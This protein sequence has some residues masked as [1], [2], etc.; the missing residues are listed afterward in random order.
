[1]WCTV[2]C[3]TDDGFFFFS[4]RRRHTRL[5]GDWSSDVCSSDLRES[6]PGR[7]SQ[8]PADHPGRRKT[9]ERNDRRRAHLGPRG[10]GRAQ[11]EPRTGESARALQHSRVGIPHRARQA[12][13]HHP[14]RPLRPSRCD[15]GREA[16]AAY[17]EQPP[18]ERGE[19]LSSRQRSDLFR[20]PA[21]RARRDRD[22]GSGNRDTPGRP[23]ADVRELSSRFE[24]REP[25][26]H[27]PGSCDREEGGGASRRRNQP[28]ER[29]RLRNPVHRY[30][31][32]TAGQTAGPSELM[33]AESR[34]KVPVIDDAPSNLDNNMLMLKVERYAATGAENGRVGLELARSDPPDLILCDVMMPEMDG[35]AVLEALRAEP[36]LAEIPFI[37]LTALDDRS[38]TRR[39]MNLG[40]DDYLP[41]PFTRNELMEAVNSRLKKF[42]NLK[43][44]LAAR[45]VPK[46]DRLT[47]KFRAQ[48]SGGD[49]TTALGGPDSG[50]PTGQIA[51]ASVLFSDIR[52]FTTY[53]ERLTSDEIAELLNAYLGTACAP[54]IRCRGAVMKFIG[55]GVM[56]L[57]ESPQ[58]EGGESH[59]QRAVRAGLAMQLAALE[60]RDWVKQ[61]HPSKSLPEFSIGV[62]IHSGE[63]LLCHVGAPGRGELTLIGD[64]VNIASRLE[65][66]TKELGWAVV[67]SEATVNAAGSAPVVGSRRQVQLRGRSAPTGAVGFIGIAA[68]D[69]DHASVQIPEDM[70]QA[71]APNPRVAP[72]RAKA[73]LGIT[74]S[75]MTGE[76]GEKR[77]TVQGY[78]VVSKVGRG[79]GSRSGEHTS[80]PPPP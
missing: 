15:H 62:G 29:G 21:Q 72:Q 31:S 78:H 19:V 24:R 56:A 80:G 16:A 41:K 32:P 74:L 60:F 63:V 6:E 46:Q 67:A 68:G 44:S 8:P 55:D 53:S 48:I 33:A 34:H 39:G 50:T 27:R 38:S 14:G 59:S 35:F 69:A 51:E 2:M 36:R 28:H 10:V 25:P 9:H 61:H 73:A 17:P 18:L 23:A 52:N 20:Q 57:F 13:R 45:I 22:P 42:E 65:G 11:V 4:S 30:D 40:A 5:Q 7:E 70:R 3:R 37:F 1:M 64:A 47:Q 71:P 43:Q 75:I 54:I 26:R 12:A 49:G 66:Q 58:G 79:G 76:I 77:L